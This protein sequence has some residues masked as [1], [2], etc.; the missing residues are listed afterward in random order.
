MGKG[1]RVDVYLEVRRGG[2]GGGGMYFLNETKVP[3]DMST[4]G[5]LFQFT[6]AIYSSSIKQILSSFH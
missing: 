2:G 3:V 6:S 5:L 1:E 4:R